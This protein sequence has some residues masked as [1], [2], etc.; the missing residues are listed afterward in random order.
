MQRVLNLAKEESGKMDMH[1]LANG[2]SNKKKMS[3]F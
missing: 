1:L 2:G 3:I